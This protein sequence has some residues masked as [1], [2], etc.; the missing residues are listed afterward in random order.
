[1]AVKRILP[2]EN[3]TINNSG[4]TFNELNGVANFDIN[5]SDI[6]Y[7]NTA[8]TETYGDINPSVKLQNETIK[9]ILDKMFTTYQVPSF[10]AFTI[11]TNLTLEVGVALMGYKTFNWGTTNSNNV[12]PNSIS[13]F[14]VT[15][16][17]L[18]VSGLTNNGST[19][20]NFST[21][22]TKTTKTNN[23]FKI[24]ATNTNNNLFSRTLD[25]NWQMKIYYGSSTVT[26]FT[27]NGSDVLINFDSGSQLRSTALG[28]YTFSA[29]PNSYKYIFVPNGNGYSQ[30][31]VFK[32]LATGFGIA[33]ADVYSVIININGNDYEYFVYRTFNQLNSALTIVAS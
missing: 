28:N 22:I 4:A 23:I 6:R 27:N 5:T 30:P 12:K 19:L 24:E 14:D 15:N 21:P 9:N 26:D 1:M 16:N 29:L 33:L 10:T 2:I 8:I 31:T 11:N 18:L 20:Y 13:L 3:I 32:D 17:N 25:I 7:T